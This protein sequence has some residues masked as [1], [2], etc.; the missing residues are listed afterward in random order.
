MHSWPKST[1]STSLSTTVRPLL[2]QACGQVA[3][4]FHGELAQRV[5]QR[6]RQRGQAGADFDHGFAAL[7]RDVA[8]WRR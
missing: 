6:L 1:F 8:S 7:W 3:V 5:Q 2:A 4:D